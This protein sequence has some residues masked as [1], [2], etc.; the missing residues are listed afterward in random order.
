MRPLSLL[1]FPLYLPTHVIGISKPYKLIRDCDTVTN[2][3]FT[4]A[5]RSTEEEIRENK[6]REIS[7]TEREYIVESIHPDPSQFK[8]SAEKSRTG[9]HNF[10]NSQYSLRMSAGSLDSKVYRN[11]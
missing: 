10:P 6:K 7:I 4:L 5:L 9:G 2:T 11:I 8:V 1:I 3:S